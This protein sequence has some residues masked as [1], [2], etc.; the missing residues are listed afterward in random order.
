[1]FSLDRNIACMTEPTHHGTR[2]RGDYHSC[3]FQGEV[4]LTLDRKWGS[5]LSSACKNTRLHSRYKPW[6]HHQLFFFLKLWRSLHRISYLKIDLQRCVENWPFVRDLLRGL[7]CSSSSLVNVYE[8]RM[9]IIKEP[10]SADDSSTVTCCDLSEQNHQTMKKTMQGCKLS[11]CVDYTSSDL[12]QLSQRLLQR[13]LFIALPNP[14]D[15][16]SG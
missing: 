1:M 5:W 10:C 12:V 2:A 7:K 4:D 13:D 16:F 3:Y 15:V 14:G 8:Y 11:R 9:S 6:S